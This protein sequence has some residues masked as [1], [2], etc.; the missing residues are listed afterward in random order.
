MS[1]RSGLNGG[2]KI[3]RP[4]AWLGK[5][6]LIAVSLGAFASADAAQTRSGGQSGAWRG[7][8]VPSYANGADFQVEADE[9]EY[10]IYFRSTDDVKAVFGFYRDYLRKQGFRVARSRTKIDGFKAD[11]VRGRGGPND[12]I[13][14]DVKLKD[15]RHKVEIEFDE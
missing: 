15:G 10:E 12:T 3:D 8:N 2:L 4:A 13:E 9:D 7:L 14:L 11:M 6:A 5:A 1:R